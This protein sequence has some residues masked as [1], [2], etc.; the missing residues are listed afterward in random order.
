[1]LDED[2]DDQEDG[3][4]DDKPEL[5]FQRMFFVMMLMRATLA[6]VFMFM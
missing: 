1:M 4:N 5:L 3:C 2:S 6:M